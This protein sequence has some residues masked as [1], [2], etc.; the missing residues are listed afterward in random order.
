MHACVYIYIY[1]HLFAVSFVCTLEQVFWA[2]VHVQ[3]CMLH[4]CFF[5][6]NIHICEHTRC[7]LCTCV[8]MHIYVYM[9]AY[10]CGYVYAYMILLDKLRRR[11]W[12]FLSVRRC[13]YACISICVCMY[14]CICACVSCVYMYICMFVYMYAYTFIYTRVWVY[15][16]TRVGASRLFVLSNFSTTCVRV[17]QVFRNTC[18]R[19]CGG[20]G[21]GVFSSLFMVGACCWRGRLCFGRGR[22]RGFVLY[23]S[24]FLQ[25]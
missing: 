7:R 8:Y 6:T 12:D 17:S 15:I 21:S 2:L 10:V 16:C 14:A 3:V 1:V 9:H 20:I 25:V 4:R 23:I 18:M 24:L 19:V 22:D 5:D 13:A 11:Y